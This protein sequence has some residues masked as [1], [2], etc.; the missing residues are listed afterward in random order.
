[1][2]QERAAFQPDPDYRL[3][4]FR[5]SLLDGNRYVLTNDVGEHVVLS[6]EDLVAFARRALPPDS[7]SYKALKSRHFMFDRQSRVA[8]DLLALKYR[9]RAEQLADFTGLH[10]FVVTLRC[11]HSCPYCQVSRQVEDRTRFDM[12]PEHADRALAL[13]FQSPSPSLKI[14]FQGGEPLLNFGLIRYVVE[15]ALALNQTQGRNLQFVIATN[16]SRLSEEVLDFCREH[17]IF[18]S[19]SLDGPEDLHNAQRPV[20]GGDSHQRTVA[21]IR[22]ARE[23]LGEQAVSALMTTTRTSLERVEEIID[24]YVRLGFHGIFLRNLSPYGFAVRGKLSQAYDVDRWIAFYKRGLAHILKLNARGYALREEFTA[25]LL[26]KL[27]SPQ[28]ANYVDLQSPAGLGIGALVYNYDGFVYASDEGRMLAEMGDFSFRLG[29]VAS[30]DAA[31]LLTSE[32]LLA[33]LSDTMPEGVPMC[34]DCAF[35]PLCGADPVF[36]R[37]TQGDAVGHKAFSA[38][39]KKQMA[40]LRHVITLLEDEPSARE[41]LLGWL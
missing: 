27:F 21:A 15:R 18:L 24:E 16:L 14:E 22:R 38:F 4:P 3:A 40:V 9:T 7:A 12:T 31:A 34:S 41:T 25:I 28:G 23:A 33:H 32:S 39:C 36:H 37:A 5:F 1:M 10:I 13:T 11:D 20:R 29:H 6:R 19:T 30:D 26:Q 35:L 8:L 17:G 2:F